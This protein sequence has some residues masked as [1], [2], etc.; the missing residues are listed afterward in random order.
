MSDPDH[1]GKLLLK[2]GVS[3]DVKKRHAEWKSQCKSYI[4]D[5]RGWW[6]QTIIEAKDD[7]E[8]LIQTLIENDQQGDLD[9]VAAKLERL[10]VR[11]SCNDCHLRHREIFLFPRVKEGKYFGR[12]W[13]DIIKPV[14]RRWGLFLMKYHAEGD[15]PALRTTLVSG[16]DSPPSLLRR[17]TYYECCSFFLTWICNACKTAAKGF[18]LHD[19][20]RT[21][22]FIGLVMLHTYGLFLGMLSPSRSIV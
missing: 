13:E 7:D 21:L 14:I 18:M 4:K 16:P 15:A 19:T 20:S 17:P 9:P 5:V 10:V 22:V 2:V 6:P 1:E 8:T 12:E 3:E 11:K